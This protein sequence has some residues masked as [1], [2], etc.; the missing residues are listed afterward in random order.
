MRSYL[1]ELRDLGAEIEATASLRHLL[2][3]A[4]LI[5]YRLDRQANFVIL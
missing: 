5:E 4:I 2:P 1:R 3:I